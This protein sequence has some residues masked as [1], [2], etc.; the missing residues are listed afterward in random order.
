MLYRMAKLT[1]QISIFT[2]SILSMDTYL[3]GVIEVD[4]KVIL[5]DGIRREMVKLIC[6]ILERVLVFKLGTIE[7]FEKRITLL[8]ENLEG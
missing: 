2:D 8:S 3:I 4:P 1:Y 5:E 6:K 7:D